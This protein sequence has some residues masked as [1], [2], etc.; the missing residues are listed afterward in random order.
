MSTTTPTAVA[1]YV[2]GIEKALADLPAAEVE[3][4]V[5]DIGQ[6]LSE[7]AGELGEEVSVEALT[8]RLG[9][10]EQYASELR[11]AAGYP[12]P[13]ATPAAGRG[14]LAARAAVWGLVSGGLAAVLAGAS[15][16]AMRLG[17]EFGLVV[18]LSL[19]LLAGI[20]LIASGVARLS[21]I[22][23]LPEYRAVTRLW[24]R[25]MDALPAQAA[26]YLRSLRPAWWLIRLLV[27]VIAILVA[28]RRGSG[29]VVLLLV[30]A[31]AVLVLF[32]KRA[33][34]DE[35]WRWVIGPANVFTVV[36]ALA[37][38]GTLSQ[39]LDSDY[40]YVSDDSMPGGLYNVDRYVE[41]VYAFG[42]D[43]KPLPEVYL[44]D[45][46]GQPISLEEPR[47]DRTSEINNRYPH[48][49]V[50]DD[51]SHCREVTGVP[52]T[53]AIP[54]SGTAPSTPPTT[55]PTTTTPST[56]VATPPPSK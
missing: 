53:V 13:T 56:T 26:V 17:K 36:V 52:F 16:G 19:P 46:D 28:L 45:Q 23:S 7:V 50:E 44:Y 54:Q 51:G 43:G 3:E 29:D 42:P 25:T 30:V 32:G 41:N 24:R 33:R 21:T 48:A 11:A 2:A 40:G 8:A 31:I 18:L 12:P 6:H 14:T 47:C 1:E 10:P 9:S 4:I 27:L 15:V 35:R 39:G 22:V 5:E 38:T 34:T 20:V 55:P 49:R 37:L